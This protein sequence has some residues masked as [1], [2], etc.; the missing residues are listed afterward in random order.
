MKQAVESRPGLT[1]RQA[2]VDGL[3]VENGRIKGVI[4]QLG[5][6]VPGKTVILTTGTFLR[7]LIHVGLAH[8]P[9]GR[10]GEPPAENM[11]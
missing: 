1:V 11:S 3:W 7:G 9:A 10:A 5:E 6:K 8:Y 4:T 2:M